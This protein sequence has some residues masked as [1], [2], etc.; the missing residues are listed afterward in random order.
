MPAPPRSLPLIAL[1]LGAVLLVVQI[2]VIGGGRTWDDVRY[3][4]EVAPPRLASAESVQLGAV[5]GWWDGS[6]LGVP[7]AGEPS[8]GA[9]YPPH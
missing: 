9:L 1:V 8:H 3:H 2:S 4:T 6:G 5:P 7:L